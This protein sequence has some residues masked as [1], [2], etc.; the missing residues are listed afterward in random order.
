MRM[1][2]PLTVPQRIP[3]SYSRDE[4]KSGTEG[5]TLVARIKVDGNHA[6]GPITIGRGGY[7]SSYK[8]RR[9]REVLEGK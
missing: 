1:H 6:I 9:R 2:S 4:L 3:S 7:K 8:R 5:V